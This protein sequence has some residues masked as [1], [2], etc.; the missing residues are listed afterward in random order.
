MKYSELRDKGT[1]GEWLFANGD[2]LP[3]VMVEGGQDVAILWDPEPGAIDA[4]QN[5]P[6]NARLIVHEHNMF[7]EMVELARELW[8]M[9]DK[10]GYQNEWMDEKELLL[11]KAEEV[12]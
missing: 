7:L 5:A 8:D 6:A 3:G 2:H 4:L 10:D 9:R 12:P 1:A 11:K